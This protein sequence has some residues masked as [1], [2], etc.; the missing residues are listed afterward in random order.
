M[1]T[2][3]I[4]V[5]PDDLDR[6][7][8]LVEAFFESA[9]SEMDMLLPDILGWL[10]RGEGLLWIVAEGDRLLTAVTTSIEQRR[11]GSALVLVANGGERIERW[12]HHLAEIEGY[13][14]R[15]RGCGKARCIGRPGWSRMLPGYAVKAVSLEK[16]L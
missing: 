15:E 14:A 12:L 13:Y 5:G 1:S 6:T 7:W 10:K 2:S 4:C 16:R 3:L 9:Y 11:S 8:P